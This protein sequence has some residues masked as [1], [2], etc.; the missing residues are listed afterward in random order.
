MSTTVPSLVHDP[1]SGRSSRPAFGRSVSWR[2]GFLRVLGAAHVLVGLTEL[3]RVLGNLSMQVGY[4]GGPLGLLGVLTLQVARF[5]NSLAV[6]SLTDPIEFWGRSQWIMRTAQVSQDFFVA[7][8]AATHRPGPAQ[9]CPGP[10]ALAAAA[11]GAASRD[12]AGRPDWH[13][14]CRPRR[15]APVGGGRVEVVRNGRPAAF[16]PG[17][18]ADPLRLAVAS[19]GGPLRGEPSGCPCRPTPS[20]VVDVVVTVACGP[21]GRDPGR[22]DP[23]PAESWPHGGNCLA[24]DLR[25]RGQAVLM[26][27]T[28]RRRSPPLGVAACQLADQRASE[29]PGCDLTSPGRP[30]P[31]AS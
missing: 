27:W 15:V 7:M 21:P 3:S 30:A 2:G 18:R 6:A 5:L 1:D 9:H 17:H 10:G 8:V 25:N 29:P 13:R 23:A 24:R 31:R 20:S 14:R 11:M 26:S 12:P 4:L 16:A 28:G 22:R 19:N